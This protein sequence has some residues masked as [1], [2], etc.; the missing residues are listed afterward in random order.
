M[1]NHK[2]ATREQNVK[3]NIFPMH[4][5]IQSHFLNSDPLENK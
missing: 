5:H 1:H 2:N 4:T 3:R